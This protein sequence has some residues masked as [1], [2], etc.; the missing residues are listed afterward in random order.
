MG[1][2]GKFKPDEVSFSQPRYKNILSCFFSRS[3]LLREDSSITIWA[4]D[5]VYLHSD[6]RHVFI[7]FKF[8]LGRVECH[9]RADEQGQMWEEEEHF[10]SGGRMLR[11]SICC[12]PTLYIQDNVLGSLPLLHN[13]KQSKH[14]CAEVQN[15]VGEDIWTCSD[16]VVLLVANMVKSPSSTCVVHTCLCGCGEISLLFTLPGNLLKDTQAA[17]RWQPCCCFCKDH[18]C[19]VFSGKFMAGSCKS[20]ADAT[21]LLM[22]SAILSSQR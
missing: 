20:A 3:S 21:P 15:C 7:C 12:P 2:L 19:L 16:V 9:C 6:I 5:R 18:A 11:P 13:K 8:T 14:E 1:M 4:P 10:G 22:A 17:S